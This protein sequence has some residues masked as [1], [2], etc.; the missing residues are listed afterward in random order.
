MRARPFLDRVEAGRDLAAS[1]RT[2][3]A[4][5]AIVVGLARGGVI[6]AAEVARGLALP[7]DVLAVRKVGHPLQPEYAVGAVTPGGGVCVEDSHGLTPDELALAVENAARRANA[8][9]ER[10]HAGTPAL[11]LTGRPCLLVDD[12]L[13]TGASMC[14]AVEWARARG[15]SRVTVAVPVGAVESV[16]SLQTRAD[17]VVC[18]EQP[19]QFAAVGYWYVDFGQVPDAAVI[20]ALAAARRP[21]ISSHD[22][23]I[24]VGDLRLQADVAVPEHAR[25][26]VIFA[27]GSGS[28]RRSPRNLQVAGV[29]NEAGFATL[30]FDLL[31]PGEELDRGNVF[32]IGLLAERLAAVTRWAASDP[33]CAPLP[34]GYFGASTGAA[35][36]LSAATQLDVVRAIVSRGGRPDLA[37]EALP[38]VTVPTL[39]IVGGADEL[40]LA[41]NREAAAQL[42]C[43][44]EVAIVPRA[45]HLFEESGALDRVAAL[46]RDW[47]LT[48][49]VTGSAAS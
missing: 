27:H 34:I 35:A 2:V 33:V 10:L 26:L 22:P 15:A 43:D 6:V 7:L 38:G 12:G 23:S 47:F 40:V 31:T 25:G 49:L 37:G 14:A 1:L 21:A 42:H 24:R 11:P 44:H 13:A 46:A 29:L 9:D 5:D 48:H 16:R 18:L 45:T 4:P 32:D 41:L 20:A 28:S 17:E 39:L 30:L 3:A 36:A 8:L 19:A